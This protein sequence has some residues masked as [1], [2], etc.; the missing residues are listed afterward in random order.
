MERFRIGSP[1]PPGYGNLRDYFALFIA[2]NI[3][4]CSSGLIGIWKEIFKPYKYDCCLIYPLQWQ[5][6]GRVIQEVLVKLISF[7]NAAYLGGLFLLLQFTGSYITRRNWNNKLAEK[8]LSTA[9]LLGQ[10]AL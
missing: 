7:S 4:N 9:K 1:G 2:P 5:V 6:S 3:P 10:L 8:I